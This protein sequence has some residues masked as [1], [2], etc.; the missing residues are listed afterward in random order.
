MAVID[1]YN[2]PD[3]Y[4]IVYAD[5]PWKQSRGGKKAVRKNSS[6]K[7]LDYQTESLEAIEEQL[8]QAV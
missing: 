6:G 3:K 5:P 4:S 2:T 7:P 1:I 8:R